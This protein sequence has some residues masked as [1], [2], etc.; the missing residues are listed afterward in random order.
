MR[1]FWRRTSEDEWE[2]NVTPMLDI[3]FIMLIFFIVTT[4][5][6]QKPGIEPSRPWAQTAETKERGNILIAVSRTDEVWMNNN[7]ITLPGVRHLVEAAIQETPG[8][9]VVIIADQTASTGIV[10]DL[11]DQVRSAGVSNIS[12]AAEGLGQL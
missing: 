7:R 9:S 4:V 5:F 3:V 12:L 1:Q 2:I 6:V 10:L 11:M 8:S